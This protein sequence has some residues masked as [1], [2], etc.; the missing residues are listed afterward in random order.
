MKTNYLAATTLALG[1][2]LFAGNSNA[3][4]TATGTSTATVIAPIEITAMLPL[5]FGSFVAGT[6]G[7]VTVNTDNT[8]DV[9]GL[10]VESAVGTV[11][12]ARFDV[13]GT[14]AATYS[15]A[16]DDDA[17]LSGP[18][19]PMVLAT[20]SALVGAASC[21]TGANITEGTLVA[22]AQSFYVGGT[23]LVAASQAEGDYSGTFDVT[24]EY[25]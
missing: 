23:L 24:V 17:I 2:A 15:I 19:V 11:S 12:A 7:S 4:D 5:A 1:A 18:G 6:G 14:G 13:D 3:E 21:A 22:G 9:T 10:V 8:R 16:I 20:C 25:N